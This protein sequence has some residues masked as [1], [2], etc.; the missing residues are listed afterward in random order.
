MLGLAMISDSPPLRDESAT[1]LR[2]DDWHARA[3]PADPRARPRPGILASRVPT[4][5]ADRG[6]RAST[7]PTSLELVSVVAGDEE[8]NKILAPVEE[9]PAFRC[10]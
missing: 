9:R 10:R 3:R 8:E 1:Q 7:H 6:A 2:V 4:M 5:R